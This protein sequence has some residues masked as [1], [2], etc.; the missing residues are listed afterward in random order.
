MRGRCR[1]LQNHRYFLPISTLELEQREDRAL[2]D[3]H[4]LERGLQQLATLAELLL[5]PI[6]HEDGL[7]VF[8]RVRLESQLFVSLR[9]A[10]PAIARHAQTHRVD[11]ASECSL[12]VEPVEL[13]I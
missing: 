9:C 13:S 2:L 8:V 3:R 10:A 4:C 1:D 11:P 6:V 7:T 12:A 5:V